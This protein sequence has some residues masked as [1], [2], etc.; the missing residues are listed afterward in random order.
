MKDD[1]D[2]YR[3]QADALRLYKLLRN[4]GVPSENIIY[5]ADDDIRDQNF[6]EAKALRDGAEIDYSG[7]EVNFVTLSRVL[8]GTGTDGEGRPLLR[9]NEADYILIYIVGHASGGVLEFPDSSRMTAGDLGRLTEEMYRNQRYKRMLIIAETCDG[10]SLEMNVTSPGIL[11]ISASGDTEPAFATDFDEETDLWY[12]DQFS[13]TLL[14][15]VKLSPDLLLDD[16]NV[17]LYLLVKGSHV[18]FM[19][20]ENF[21]KFNLP[22]REFFTP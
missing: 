4:N 13:S 9:T 22:I 16:F 12:S 10:G 8:A 11:Y 19:N 20:K 1:R 7:N 5:I 18:R 21:G 3:H 6:P 14:S 17:R 2:N 15:L